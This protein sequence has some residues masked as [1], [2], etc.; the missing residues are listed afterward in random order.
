MATSRGYFDYIYQQLSGIEDISFR[1]MMGEYVIYYRDK[2]IGGLYDDRFLIKPAKGALEL[3]PKASE[4]IPYEG[5]KP[6]L[7]VEETDDAAFLTE[8][9]KKIYP[10]L[11]APKKKAR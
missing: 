5:A 10:E 8:L 11:P 1:P 9:I 4:E 7:L 2:I 6:M 3:M